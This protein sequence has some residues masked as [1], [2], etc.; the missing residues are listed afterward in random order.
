MGFLIQLVLGQLYGRIGLGWALWACGKIQATLTLI[1]LQQNTNTAS[2]LLKTA[3]IYI[4]LQI[5]DFLI[6]QTENF[7][8]SWRDKKKKNR[9]NRTSYSPKWWFGLL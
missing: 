3:Y 5:H 4:D 7:D 9:P 2:K 1:Y 8:F 6:L